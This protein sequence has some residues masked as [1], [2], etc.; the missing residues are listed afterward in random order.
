MHSA[1]VWFSCHHNDYIGD[2]SNIVQCSVLPDHLAEFF[3]MH[4]QKDI[5]QL[6][7][8]IGKNRYEATILIHLVLKRILVENPPNGKYEFILLIFLLVIFF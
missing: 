7:F 5:E 3:W 8:T 4:L 6:S 2:L 1:F